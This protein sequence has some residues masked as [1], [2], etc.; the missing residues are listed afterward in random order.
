[1]SYGSSANG[2][3]NDLCEVS[4]PLRFYAVDFCPRRTNERSISNNELQSSDVRSEICLRA[5]C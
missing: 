1:M 2:T 5:E 3:V 4:K